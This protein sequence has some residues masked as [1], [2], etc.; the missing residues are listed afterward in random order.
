MSDE[1]GY[2]LPTKVFAGS[3]QISILGDQAKEFGK[4][5]L[6]IIPQGLDAITAPAINQLKGGDFNLS[7]EELEDAE[8]TIDFINALANRL[9]GN[10]YDVIIGLGGGSAIDVAKA[11]S[12]AL[13]H[14]EDIWL[15]ANLSN[16]PALPLTAPLI[17]VISVAT[18]SGT[19]SEVTPYAVLTKEDTHQ[20]G[21]IQE[22]AIFPKVAILDPELITSLP[23]ALTASTG[24]DAFAHA[25]EAS[26]NISKNA[27]AAET[28]GT[29]AMKKLFK[30]L[31]IAYREPDNVKARMKVSWASCLAGMAISHRGTTTAHS[32]AEPLGGLTHIPHGL[33]VSIATLPVLRHTIAKDPACLAKLNGRVLGLTA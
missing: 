1:F 31:P 21:T 8:P 18:T 26:I 30:W 4:D 32:I 25:L 22:P 20:K 10:S 16:R 28:F 11:L 33:G 9:R 13:T 19:G 15:Y 6:L 27:P 24:L 29:S 17:P 23:P 14:S 5:V 12:I 7:I 3:G 2:Y